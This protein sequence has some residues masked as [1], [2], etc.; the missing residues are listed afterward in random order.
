MDRNSDDTA[1][2]PE[3]A[4]YAH[5][6]AVGVRLGLF[7]LVVSFSLYVFGVLEPLVPLERLPEYWSMSASAYLQEIEANHVHG[8]HALH[9]W[10]WTSALNHGDCCNLLGIA[11]LGIVTIVCYL[12]ILPILIRG[13]DRIY[14][15]IAVTE[16]LVLS[17]AAS[18]LLTVGGH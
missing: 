7:L 9:G 1:L 17:L 5:V 16:I 8:E 3:Q 6:L 13:R 18:G 12:A 2:S 14:T 11:L 15:A 4:R 10:G